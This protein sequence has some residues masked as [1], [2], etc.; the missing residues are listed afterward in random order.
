MNKGQENRATMY[1]S[2]DT[3]LEMNIEKT[4]EIPAFEQSITAFR[5]H[6]TDLKNKSLEFGK[7]TAGKSETKWNA[8]DDLIGSLLPVASGLKVLAKRKSN[9]ELAEIVDVTETSLRRMRDTEL[10]TRARTIH[11]EAGKL[12]AD[13]VQ[14]GATSEKLA[15]LGVKID[16]YEK[17]I[18]GR[19]SSVAQRMGARQA[20]IDL[21]GKVDDDLEEIDNLMELLRAK[22]P[23]FYNEYQAA[24][25]VKDTGVRHR[26]SELPANTTQQ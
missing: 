26:K 6:S 15:D 14:F 1:T 7:A 22:Y 20:M 10:V 21:F 18:G 9:P 16:A 13:L 2:V 5:G 23:D 12:T 3:L 8:E 17:S 19:E 4:G 25:T 11:T 24:R